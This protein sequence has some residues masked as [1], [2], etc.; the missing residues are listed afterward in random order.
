MTIPGI[1]RLTAATLMAAIGDVRRFPSPRHLV[2]YLG[3]DPGVRQSGHISKQGDAAARHVLV[4]AAHSVERAPGPLRA[5]KR[6]VQARRGF[7]IA[8]VAVARKLATIAWHLLTKQED[9]AY[10][11]PA[12]THR[13]LRQA[14]LAAGAP[15]RSNPR[16]SRGPAT[17]DRPAQWHR[18]REVA[19]QASEPTSGSSR[20][21]PQSGEDRRVDLLARRPP[22]PGK[23]KLRVSG[24]YDLKFHPSSVL[25]TGIVPGPHR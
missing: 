24:A 10:A 8:M 19:E 3:L 2:G 18:E 5:F 21:G 9:Y 11:R 6:R 14:E 12:L 17:P 4:E 22:Q 20:T 23:V 1:S 15:K 13:K 25:L 7:Q 16:G